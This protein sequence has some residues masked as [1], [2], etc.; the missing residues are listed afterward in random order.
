M[1]SKHTTMKFGGVRKLTWMTALTAA[2]VGPM[3]AGVPTAS[4]G[5]NNC[6]GIW[7]EDGRV[8]LQHISS[9]YSYND[10]HA[11]HINVW[12][13]GR[14]L[15]INYTYHNRT[16]DW[17]RD[18]PVADGTTVCAEIWHHKPGGGYDSIGLPCDTM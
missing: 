6:A 17:W 14:S 16:L 12:G 9:C 11:H 4:A 1:K 10:G 13:G 3:I 5:I 18:Y 15:T 7:A 2:F 8:H